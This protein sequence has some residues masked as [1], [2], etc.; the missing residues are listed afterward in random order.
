MVVVSSALMELI[1]ARE[2]NDT[3]EAEEY[4][5]RMGIPMHVD[6]EPGG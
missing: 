5:D 2:D 3:M 4:Y 6:R 1:W